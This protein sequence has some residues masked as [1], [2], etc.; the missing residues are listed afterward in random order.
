[1]TCCFALVGHAGAGAHGRRAL[2]IAAVGVAA[3]LPVL[4]HAH[5]A[6]D[7]VLGLLPAASVGLPMAL[8]AGLYARGFAARW[9]R[10]LSPA[11]WVRA[12]AFVLGMLLLGAALLGPL[13]S[14]AQRSFAAHMAQHMVL[15]VLAPPVLLA[16][17]PFALGLRALPPV[18][19]RALLAP[20][21]WPG[22]AAVRRSC[23]SVGAMAG[24]HA[25]VL[26][27]WHIP[28]LFDAA[29]RHDAVHWLEHATLLASGLLFW[30]ALLRARGPSLARA[31]GALLVTTLHTGMLGAVLSLS[32]RVL[33]RS[34]TGPDALA[35]Q[36]LAGLIMW[37]PMG[38]VYLLAAVWL[39]SRLLGGTVRLPQRA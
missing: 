4:A 32:P 21:R 7:T 9:A 3:A 36:Q 30:R 12:T 39:A 22:A 13:D 27:S 6:S 33:Y 25:V 19:R 35:G 34:Y 38:T 23:A 2:R 28:A 14:W 10:G 5:S 26:W 37:V 16:A 24:L 8:A 18:L 20:R 1:M 11:D 15:V 31:L 29:L 17:R